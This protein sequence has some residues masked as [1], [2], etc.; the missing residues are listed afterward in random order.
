MIKKGKGG[1]NTTT[2]LNFEKRTDIL[3]LLK[4]QV[5]TPFE[6]VVYYMKIK[7]LQGVI[8]RMVY[9]STLS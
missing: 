6:G 7:R 9:I 2:G 3:S 4:K 5:V 1:G 8:G